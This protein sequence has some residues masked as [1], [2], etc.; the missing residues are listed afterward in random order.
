M[1]VVKISR[2]I[3]QPPLCQ[4]PAYATDYSEWGRAHLYINIEYEGDVTKAL[5]YAGIVQLKY[6]IKL[7]RGICSEVQDENGIPPLIIFDH[8][9]RILKQPDGIN[10]IHNL[11]DMV[12]LMNTL[13][14]FCSWRVKAPCPISYEH[15]LQGQECVPHFTSGIYPTIEYITCLCQNASNKVPT[16]AVHYF[17]GRFIH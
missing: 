15:V 12:Q 4:N 1:G 10:T 14:R 2:A 9:A 6:A 16:R 7:L 3:L 13:G 11:Q 17:G 8:T 5:Y